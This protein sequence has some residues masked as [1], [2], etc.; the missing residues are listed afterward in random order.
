MDL[1]EAIG[2]SHDAVRVFAA[3]NPEPVKLMFSHGEDVMLANPWGPAVTG[4]DRVSPALDYASSRF[5]D[6]D[7]GQFE[8]VASYATDALAVIHETETWRA[9]VAGREEFS[10]FQLRVTTTFRCEDGDWKVVHRHAD[11][12]ATAQPDGPLQGHA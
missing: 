10:S 4:W 7:V 5:K 3:G 12:I 6:G 11:P 1:T 2:R 9:K 8:T